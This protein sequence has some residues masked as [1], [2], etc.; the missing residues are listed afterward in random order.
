MAPE[1]PLRRCL[2]RRIR[3][4]SR[5]RVKS[6]SFL[7]PLLIGHKKRRL[8]ALELRLRLQRAAG[9]AW[10]RKSGAKAAMKGDF[11]AAAADRTE[12]TTCTKSCVDAAA[13]PSGALA[14]Q[15]SHC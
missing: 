9:G 6:F 14:T 13:A 8:A 12:G 10:L 11:S 15:T 5:G 1:P 2:R 4:R 7:H 3:P